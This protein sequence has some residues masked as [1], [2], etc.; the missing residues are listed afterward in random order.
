[1]QK[2]SITKGGVAI[3]H[4]L[5]RFSHN[6]AH[7]CAFLQVTLAPKIN[8]EKRPRKRQNMHENALFCTGACHT[9][10]YYTVRTKNYSGSGTCF[11][12]LISER[13]LI[14]LRDRPCLE[15][16]IVSSYFLLVSSCRTQITEISLTAIHS[17]KKS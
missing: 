16:I 12:E 17:S 15:S 7:I 8:A 2:G 11:Q 13:L 9:P 5:A 4:F 10:G 14:L 1:M 6:S 3:K